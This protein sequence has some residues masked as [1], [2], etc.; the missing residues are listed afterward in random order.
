MDTLENSNQEQAAALE[1][2]VKRANNPA[3]E[4]GEGG[5][6]SQGGGAGDHDIERAVMQAL[7]PLQNMANVDELVFIMNHYNQTLAHFAATFGYP[8]LLRRLD[9]D[10]TTA[11]VNGLTALHCA[12][13]GGKKA[14]IELLNAGAPENVL[15]ALGQTPAHLMPNVFEAPEMA[16]DRTLPT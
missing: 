3:R 12:Y 11:D 13:G 4:Q 1:L 9:I 7:E 8:K 2:L 6:G 14:L 10:V 16:L 15:D 5:Q